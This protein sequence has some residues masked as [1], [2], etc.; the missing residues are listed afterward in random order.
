MTRL[1]SACRTVLAASLCTLAGAACGDPG[2]GPPTDTGTGILT[3]VVNA[4]GP[5]VDEQYL[6]QLNGGAEEPY[7]QGTAF[8]RTLQA[9]VYNVRISGIAPNCT[10]QGE[11]LVSVAL[12]A[13][14][15]RTLTFNVTCI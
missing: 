5:N 15:E 4:T 10:L 11:A 9:S 7:V 2:G 3:I 14:R 6:I 1:L 12:L 8:V 13:G